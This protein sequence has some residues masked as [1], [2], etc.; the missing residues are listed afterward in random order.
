MLFNSKV[1]KKVNKSIVFCS[2]GGPAGGGGGN[3]KT[4][5]VQPPPQALRFLHGRGERETSDWWWTA[6]F[7]QKRDVWVRGS[8]VSVFINACCLL[9]ALPS[10]SQ[11]GRGT[12]SLVMISF[13]ALSL[14]FGPRCLSEFTLA[15]PHW[16]VLLGDLVSPQDL[17]KVLKL[18]CP[19]L[20]YYKTPINQLIM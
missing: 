6:H 14:L 9:S 12:L 2:Y 8:L 16:L 3:F 7:H 13:Y 11:F 1:F 5:R 4:S 17:A 15:G 18:K 10:L 19:L 20:N